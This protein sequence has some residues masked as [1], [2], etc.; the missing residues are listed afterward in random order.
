DDDVVACPVLQD[1]RGEEMDTYAAHRAHIHLF[2]EGASICTM[3]VHTMIRR[4]T[5]LAQY[6]A[7]LFWARFISALQQVKAHRD[8][9]Y[10]NIYESPAFASTHPSHTVCVRVCRCA[11]LQQST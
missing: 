10:L 11:G 2:H 9:R 8:T 7:G 3:C 1:L 6:R 5:A 4:T